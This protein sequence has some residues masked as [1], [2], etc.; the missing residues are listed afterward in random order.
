MAEHREALLIACDEFA[1]PKYKRLSV[2]VSDARALAKLLSDPDI[3]QF[4]VE[5]LENEQRD[6]VSDK[7]EAFFEKGRHDDVLLLYFAGHGD[8]D[9]RGNFYF[10]ARNTKSDRLRSSGIS[11]RFIHE[12]MVRSS[13]KR[14]ILMLDCC[15]SG[16][17]S[18]EWISRGDVGIKQKLAG[19]GRV[20]L[21]ASDAIEFA[22]EK[23]E[24]SG[25][26]KSLFTS[27]IIEGM[28]GGQADLDG[29]GLISVDELYKYVEERI[30]SEDP[31]QRPL[32]SGSVQ[33]QLWLSRAVPRKDAIPRNVL[34]LLQHNYFTVRLA[35]IDELERLISLNKDVLYP[36]AT[37]ALTKLLSDENP[38][39]IR[40]ADSAL[41]RLQAEQLEKERLDAE[42]SE[43]QRLEA[44][45]REKER[46]EAEHRERDRLGTEQLE[47]ER[48][49]A[50]ARHREEE[51]RLKVEQHQQERLDTQQQD[52]ERLEAKT[53]QHESEGREQQKEEVVPPAFKSGP[54]LEDAS[55]PQAKGIKI[56]ASRSQAK[57]K[58]LL[59]IALALIT[60]IGWIWFAV[61]REPTLTP[62]HEPTSITND[63]AEADDHYRRGVTFDD[64]GNSADAVTEFTEAIRLNPNFAAAYY[65]RSS[66]YRKLGQKDK[67]EAD[68]ATAR[69][70]DG[71]REPTL[72]PTHEPTSITNDRAEADDHYR[73]GVTFD[74]NGNSADA[75]TEFT[76]AIRLNPNFAAAYYRRSSAYRK[77]GQKDKAEA[78]LATARQLDGH[79]EPTLTPTHEPTSITNDRAEADDHYR[80]GVT[81]DD[82]GN[83]ADAV[84]EFTEAIR[85]NPNFA[86]AYYR[87]SSA[88]RKLGQKDKAEADLAT[89]RQLDGP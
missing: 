22:Y 27:R 69:Q 62:T 58:W 2:P 26:I 1:D 50:E 66:A 51:E 32:K 57:T 65:R 10:V 83:S 35:G 14:Q 19:E 9:D 5:L 33:G 54:S 55:S 8:L 13:S 68:L 78:D 56:A 15:Y 75:V 40:V 70:L 61:H 72:T 63:T 29:D 38:T 25:A 86:A 47:K 71:H 82:N 46:V 76:E 39:V 7:L 18:K 77:L 88:Y 16:A 89:A 3:G 87:R 12:T 4:S 67:A 44:Q 79:R 59:A 60:G 74:D 6:V 73:R 23:R 48:R 85:L 24:P 20:V 84:T 37:Q 53:L 11:D 49:E 80:R 17:F 64:N 34:D 28:D 52:K 43:K 30:R 21:T 45:Q 81:F 42:Q 31:A 41:R 36:A